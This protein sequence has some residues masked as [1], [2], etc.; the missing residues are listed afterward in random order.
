MQLELDEHRE[1]KEPT[2]VEDLPAEPQPSAFPNKS[3]KKTK[4]SKKIISQTVVYK[5][6]EKRKSSKQQEETKVDLVVT[7][8]SP[9]I[10]TVE[11]GEEEMPAKGQG[12]GEEEPATEQK[13]EGDDDII[14]DVKRNGNDVETKPGEG[15]DTG[16]EQ[17]KETNKEKEKEEQEQQEEQIKKVVPKSEI[18]NYKI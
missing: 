17:E 14:T 10:E 9:V 1:S 8:P 18:I 6:K 4:P 15:G 13:V 16:K 7:S 12:T 11:S 2:P 5:E 3:T